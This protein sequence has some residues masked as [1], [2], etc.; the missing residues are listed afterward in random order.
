ML[1]MQVHVVE[2][3]G[4]VV[5]SVTLAWPRWRTVAVALL[6][7]VLLLCVHWLCAALLCA[8]WL[9]YILLRWQRG[10]TITCV[11]H[12]GVVCERHGLLKTASEFFPL[13]AIEDV[14]INECVQ[15]MRVIVV[16]QLLLKGDPQRV[17]LLLAD[18]PLVQLSRVRAALRGLLRLP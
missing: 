9:A 10:V 11:E 13:D 17:V 1:A 5:A 15:G 6:A 16:L 18:A 14:V 8:L 2:G 4:S 3:S 7:S 12:N